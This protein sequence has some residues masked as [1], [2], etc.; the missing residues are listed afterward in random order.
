[1]KGL[2]KCSLIR[3]SVSPSILACTRAGLCVCM[4]ACIKMNVKGCI[5]FAF[6]YRPRH[7]RV[8]VSCIRVCL[9]VRAR[10]CRSKNN[11]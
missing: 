11:Q 2:K 8:L 10:R 4:C 7:V 6:L 9:H 3:F 1:M 5:F